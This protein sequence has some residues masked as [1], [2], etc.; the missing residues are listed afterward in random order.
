MGTVPTG[1]ASTSCRLVGWLA[2]WLAF[3]LAGWLASW[4]VGWL[5]GWLVVL[6][7]PVGPGGAVC[8]FGWLRLLPTPLSSYAAQGLKAELL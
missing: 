8:G 2:D 1:A 5:P 7:Q 4:S 6:A 3:W